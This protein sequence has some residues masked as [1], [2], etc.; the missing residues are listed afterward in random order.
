L[1][2]AVLHVQEAK[3]VSQAEGLEGLM[4]YFGAQEENNAQ[5]EPELST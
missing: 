5:Q 1:E 3:L 4:I 2:E